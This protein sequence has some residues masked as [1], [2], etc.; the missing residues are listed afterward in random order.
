MS[1]LFDF[2]S[3]SESGFTK[4]QFIYSV[5]FSYSDFFLQK[6]AEH[7]LRTQS[8]PSWH[9]DPAGRA[10]FL[11]DGRTGRVTTT[12]GLKRLV[13]TRAKKFHLATTITES[14]VHVP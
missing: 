2:Q 6:K 7:L 12:L 4:L 14:G 13:K 11:R 5:N 10:T 8:W 9:G 3:S 1:V